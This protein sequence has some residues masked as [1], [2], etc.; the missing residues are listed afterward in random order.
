MA[1]LKMRKKLS[2]Y[3]ILIKVL[4]ILKLFNFVSVS[5][6]FHRFFNTR[7]LNQIK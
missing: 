5:I 2:V 1:A 3:I 7:H 4:N 6:Y